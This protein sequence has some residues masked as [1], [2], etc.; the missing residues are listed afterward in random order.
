MGKL[1]MDRTETTTVEAILRDEL[2]RGNRAL[3]GVA[4]VVAHMLENSGPALVSD[5]IIARLRGMLADLAR[6]LLHAARVPMRG[7]PG[8]AIAID[9]LADA[10]AGEGAL[11]EHLHALAMEGYLTERLSQMTGLD[12]VLSP[13][14]QE[15]IASDQPAT[16]E[17]AMTTL[18]AQSRFM[19]G[20]RRMELPL[21]ELPADLFSAVLEVCEDTRYAMVGRPD[22]AALAHLR[23]RFDEGA[24]RQGLLARLVS[25][26]RGGTLA[27][28]ALNHAGLAL[29]V[30]GLAAMTR[31]P[32]AL[33]ILACHEGQAVRLALSL[34]AAG[35]EP[36]A[37]EA[38]FAVLGQI[39]ALRNGAATLPPER[40]QALLGSLPGGPIP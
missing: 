40:A 4:P 15:L 21:G 23:R 29:F 28:L 2:E 6:Q 37:V 8:D 36:A 34:R 10:L 17:L 39:E 31:Q 24:G 19:Q 1:V 35:L 25:A 22:A 33:A 7:A 38:Q 32:R 13:L 11:I 3:R 14:M 30:S 9:A 26:M 18:A 16:A 20:Q 12:P 27:A 5:A